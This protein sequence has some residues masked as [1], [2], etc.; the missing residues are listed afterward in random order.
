M[1]DTIVLALD[2]RQFEVLRPELFSPSAQGLITPPYYSLGSRGNFACVQNPTKD[3]LRAGRY[4]PRLTLSK[5]RAPNGFAL[6]LRI[7]FSAPKLLFG[8]NFDELVTHDFKVVLELLHQ[9]LTEMGVKVSRDTLRQAPISSIH[10][11]KNFAFTDYTTCSM[12]MAELDRV[13]LTKRLDLS[14]T[15][16]RNEGQA[17]RYHA[18]SFE[19]VFYDKLRDLERARYSEKRGME[20]DYSTLPLQR[21]RANLL[22]KEL[23]VLRMEV[24]LGTRAKVK[25]VLER[26]G[27]A[28]EPCF[29]SLFDADI[30]KTVLTHFWTEVRFQLALR[31]DWDGQ[32]PEELV[33]T[34]AA[35]SSG[36][37]RLSKLLRQ[38]GGAMLIG[39]I[40]IRGAEALVGRHCSPRSWQ[41]H[42]RELRGLPS[43][44]HSRFSAFKQIDDALTRFEPLRMEAFRTPHGQ[45]NLASAEL[46][47][48]S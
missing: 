25:T 42:K 21:G 17:I 5:R 2:Q 4:Q 28:A 7:E 41:R 12:V 45:G 29:E 11:G 46:E 31:N 43:I 39:S 38:L 9:K 20:R 13:D 48:R 26:T 47:S 30:A 40:G 10:Y 3:H 18:N 16:Y 44:G 33:A 37:V 14:H 1:L 23:E 27:I 22:P 15:D 6:A 19:L 24:R 32:K 35:A 36:K 8:N 34:L